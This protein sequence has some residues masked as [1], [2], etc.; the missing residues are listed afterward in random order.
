MKEFVLVEFLFADT[1]SDKGFAL[2]ESLGDDFVMLKNELE[3]DCEDPSDAD[4]YH[5]CS[6]K[7]NS[8]TA[9]VIK[10]QHPFLAEKMRISYIPE[11]LK[12]KYR[13]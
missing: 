1:E 4:S 11:D 12:N 7:I 13:G 2:L 6:G 8:M 3:W 9:S 10:L 5:R